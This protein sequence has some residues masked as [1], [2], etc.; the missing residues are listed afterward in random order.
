MS[1]MTNSL[2]GLCCGS[3][4]TAPLSDAAAERMAVHLVENEEGKTAHSYD[5]ASFG[6]DEA[7]VR[8]RFARYSARFGVG[9]AAS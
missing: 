4:R 5:L 2:D 8:A 6:L 3:L 1:S 9:R 7:E